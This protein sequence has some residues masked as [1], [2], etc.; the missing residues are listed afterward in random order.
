MKKNYKDIYNYNLYKKIYS[1]PQGLVMSISHW[2]LESR[3]VKNYNSDVLDIGSGEILHKSWMKDVG[4]YTISDS[5]QIISKK[6]VFSLKNIGVKVHFFDKD[7]NYKTLKNSSF[8]RVVLHHSLEHIPNPEIFIKNILPLIKDDGILSISLPCDPGFLWR[9]GQIIL[10]KK[11]KKNFGWNKLEYDL[12]MSR[13]HINSAHNLIKIINYY[14]SDVKWKFFPFP[15]LKI[16]EFN[17]ITYIHIK[18]NN[19]RNLDNL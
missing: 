9:F 7:P 1:G 5:S 12:I 8:S 16:I 14:F 17:L 10:R 2:L 11:V 19:F 4:N 3:K 15:F 13:E 18:K 6:K